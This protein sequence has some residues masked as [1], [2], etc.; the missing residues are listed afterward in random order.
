[1]ISELVDH[2]WQ[3]TLFVGAAGLLTLMLRKNR[4]QGRYWVWFAASMKFL[5]PFSTI[6]WSGLRRIDLVRRR[7][8]STQEPTRRSRGHAVARARPSLP[9][10][11]EAYLAVKTH[12]LLVSRLKGQAASRRGEF[13]ITTRGSGFGGGMGRPCSF[14]NPT[15]S[16]IPHFA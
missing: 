11:L 6:V 12:C 1:M 10:Q 14:S 7:I 8:A 5:V 9:Q 16:A 3:S 4:A 2:L 15:C 13:S